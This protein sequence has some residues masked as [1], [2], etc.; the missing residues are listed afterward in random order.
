MSAVLAARGLSAGYHGHPFIRDIDLEVHPG[1]VVA[2]LGPNG[3]GKTTT[4]LALAGELSAMTG[5]VELLG[6][7]RKDAM[8]RRAADGLAFVTEERSVFMQLT[9][10][11][12][13]KV[14]RTDVGRCVALF[15]EIERLLDRR[16]G[17]L[18]GGEQ[19]MVTLARALCRDP[20]VLLIDEL[21]LG[22]APL[23]VERLLAAVRQ[24]ASEHEIA[25]ILVEQKVESALTVADHVYVLQDGRIAIHGP[26]DDIRGRVREL[27]ESYLAVHP[28]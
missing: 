16:A 6:Q 21:S 26:S 7:P 17:L 4:L 27:E 19:Q 24:A 3:A 12:N 18:S 5:S 10:A 20:K 1:Q 13:L 11:E 9:A 22:L 8:H 2:L 23:I 14:G 25:V 28:A 15:P